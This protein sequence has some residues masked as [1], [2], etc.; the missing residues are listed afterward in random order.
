ME[1]SLLMPTLTRIRGATFATLNATT[2]PN[3]SLRCV[4]E[5][6]RVILFSTNGESGYEAMVKRRLAEAGKDPDCFN[7]GPL[8]WGERVGNLPLILNK[9]EYYLQCIVLAP[10]KRTYYIGTT[11]VEVDPDLLDAFGIKEKFSYG[12]GLPPEKQV[13]V[14]CYSVQNLESVVLMGERLGEYAVANGRSIL[15]IKPP[16]E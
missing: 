9:G 6:E 11:D 10:G 8:P 5:G 4:V 12:Q 1:V 14:R 16:Q 15:K 13:D 3:K 7:V 2:W